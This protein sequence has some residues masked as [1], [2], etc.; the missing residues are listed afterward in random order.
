[1]KNENLF[2]YE[3]DVYALEHIET[4][5]YA[6]GRLLESEDHLTPTISYLCDLL[7]HHG[8]RINELFKLAIQQQRQLRSED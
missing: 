2:E 5:L 4:L 1:M 3:K 7:H 8:K 6:V